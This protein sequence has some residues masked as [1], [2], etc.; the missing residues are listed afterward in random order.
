MGNVRTDM[1]RIRTSDNKIAVATHGRGLF[2]GTH[3]S[4]LPVTLSAF[5]GTQQGK[6][7]LLQWTTV[8]ELNSK[9]FELQKSY[10][11][12]DYRT[13]A[14]I[15]AAGNSNS[16]LDYSYLDKEPLTEANHYRLRSVDLDGNNKLS[17]VVLIRIAGLQQDM[18]VLNNPFRDQISIRFVKAPQTKVD[19]RLL[20]LSGRLV[21]RQQAAPGEQQ[22]LLNTGSAK[23]SRA[24]YQL[25]VIVDGKQYSQQ[26]IAQ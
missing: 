23:A 3:A 13:I 7:V 26:V 5:K 4:L 21:A 22:V 20:D 14:T 18:L 24:V 1:I 25:V 15:N 11:G 6:A 8:S 12:T 16:R 19:I 9:H 2:T 17:N 10:N